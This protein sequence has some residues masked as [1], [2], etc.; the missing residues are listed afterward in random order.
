MAITTATII[1]SFK[2]CIS[3]VHII[4]ILCT[5]Y[6]LLNMLDIRKNK[7]KDIVLKS[8]FKPPGKLTSQAT[9]NLNFRENKIAKFL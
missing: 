5:Q 7:Q 3:A 8:V 4:F 6:N 1:S 9:S 2:C